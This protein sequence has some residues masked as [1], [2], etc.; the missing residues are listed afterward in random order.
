MLSIGR[1]ILLEHSKITPPFFLSSFFLFL[2]LQPCAPL[3]HDSSVF[4]NIW[5]WGQLL[6]GLTVVSDWACLRLP[7]FLKIP[8]WASLSTRAEALRRLTIISFLIYACEISPVFYMHIGWIILNFLPS[9]NHLNRLLISD[10]LLP[11][12]Y[13]FQSRPLNLNFPPIIV[14]FSSMHC[15]TWSFAWWPR[16]PPRGHWGSVTVQVHESMSHES[17]IGTCIYVSM[18]RTQCEHLQWTCTWIRQKK[19]RSDN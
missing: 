8:P 10:S 6:G 15:T 14:V 13:P 7:V 1:P 11:Q 4:P 18:P 3:L 16:M 5:P 9:I 12:N 17:I 2:L 19:T